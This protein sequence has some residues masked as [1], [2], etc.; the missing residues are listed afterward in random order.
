M[1]VKQD[2]KLNSVVSTV[3]SKRNVVARLAEKSALIDAAGPGWKVYQV[4]VANDHDMNLDAM[5]K[6][7]EELGFVDGEKRVTKNAVGKFEYYWVVPTKIASHWKAKP[8]FRYLVAA[9][10]KKLVK[11]EV[12]AN[13]RKKLVNECLEKHVIQYVIVTTN[14]KPKTF[15]EM[16]TK[17]TKPAP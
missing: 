10:K 7:C 4:T 14:E 12:R 9:D 11:E 1:I 13:D 8:P 5:E 16:E 6:L 17:E 15:S 3:L 2:V